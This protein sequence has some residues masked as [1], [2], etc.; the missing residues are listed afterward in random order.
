MKHCHCTHLLGSAV[1]EGAKCYKCGKPFYRSEQSNVQ[2]IA[3]TT[4]EI[5][6]DI[7]ITKEVIDLFSGSDPTDTFSGGGGDF[8]GGGAD[9][10]W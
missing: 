7:V 9:G 2:G 8:G 6:A 10:D 5:M 1:R 3:E 4:L